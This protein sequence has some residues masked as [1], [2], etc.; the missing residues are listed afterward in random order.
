MR[1]MAILTA[2]LF[3][4]VSCEGDDGSSKTL[5]KKDIQE[6]S[7]DAAIGETTAEETGCT[8]EMC[9]EEIPGCDI[10]GFAEAEST[11]FIEDPA[12]IDYHLTYTGKDAAHA[13][14]ELVIEIRQGVPFNGPYS[15]GAYD[16]SGKNYSNCGL[17]VLIRQG[18]SE[19]GCQKYF[20]A[21]SGSVD[22]DMIGGA[23]IEFIASMDIEF[24]EVT[25]DQATRKS[26][27]VEGGE[28]WCIKDTDIHKMISIDFVT[29]EHQ[30]I[31]GGTG[32]KANSQI[33]DFSLM[34]CVGETVN[35]H[36]FCGAAKAVWI[37]AVAGWC[38]ACDSFV[39]K[40]AKDI[41]AY[42][43][44]GLVG[45]VVLSE[46][47]EGGQPDL[48]YCKAYAEQHKIDPKYMYIDFQHNL[49][50]TKIDPMSGDTIGLPWEALLDADDMKYIANSSAGSLSFADILKVL[51]DTYE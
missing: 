7:S 4:L 3:M 27:P 15:P 1:L 24:E 36:S 49:L 5:D 42:E 43:S 31:S 10:S 14:T 6:I 46:T 47:A 41:V 12:A 2:F 45:M 48:T 38:D 21:K 34:N 25:I 26:T 17:C 23:G 20:F 29:G 28:S 11:M 19:S 9:P 18:C 51:N 35:L 44:S 39:P 32:T 50:F 40:A 13:D 16:L 37:I 8:G 30:C 22:I 33:S